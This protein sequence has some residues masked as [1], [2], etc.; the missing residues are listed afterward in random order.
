MKRLLLLHTRA[1]VKTCMPSAQIFSFIL[2]GKCITGINKLIFTLKNSFETESH[3]VVQIGLE[4]TGVVLAG[5]EL[6]AILLP[7]P[8][9][10]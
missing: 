8:L 10:K 7:Q 1:M 3:T 5:L 9:V 6:M 4:L 2:M